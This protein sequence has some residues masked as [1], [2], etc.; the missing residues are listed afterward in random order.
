MNIRLLI[1]SHIT[2]SAPYKPDIELVIGLHKL[3]ILV[4]VMIPVN[5]PTIKTFTDLGISVVPAHPEK[6]LSLKSIRLIRRKIRQRNYD[7]IHLFNTKA[8]VNGS[9][10][11]IGL[12]VKVIAYRGAAGMHWYDPTAWLSHLNPRIDMLICNSRYVQEQMQQ[13]LLFRPKKAVMIYKGMDVNWF[14]TVKPVSRSA[15]GIPEKA[16]IVGCVANVRRIKGVPYLLEATQYINHELPVHFLLIGQG[17]ESDPIKKL[18]EASP[19]KDNIH[20]LG[21]RKDVYEV[22]AA[23]DIYV[24]PSLSESLSRSVM[25]AMCLHVPCIVSNIG[26]LVELV[27][28]EKSG[29]VAE[30]GNPRSIA[31]AIEKLSTSSDLRKEYEAEAFHRMKSIFSLDN[32][33]TNTRKWYQK[34]LS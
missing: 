11:A 16:I 26:G 27:E 20:I 10:A 6:K 29:L 13:Q 30:R 22:I 23:C 5:S 32:M 7:I 31:L 1:I 2:E 9:L 21:F 25:E 34:I 8:I 15:I 4:D 17:M 19:F 28:H 3:G 12:P 24:Q 18:I 33:V 14:H